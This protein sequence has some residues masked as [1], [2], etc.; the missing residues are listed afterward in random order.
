MLALLDHALLLVRGKACC[1]LLL[2]FRLSPRWLLDACRLKVVPSVEALAR[3]V[4]KQQQAAQQSQQPQQPGGAENQEAKTLRSLAATAAALRAE[5]GTQVPKICTSVRPAGPPS[6]PPH[7]GRD[8]CMPGPALPPE[9]PTLQPPP[10]QRPAA[11]ALR[12]H[13]SALSPWLPTH[14]CPGACYTQCH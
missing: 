11:C 8:P 3:D 1:S 12:Y 7:P 14:C 6:P 2:L 10:C 13:P 9:S 4:Q 5:V